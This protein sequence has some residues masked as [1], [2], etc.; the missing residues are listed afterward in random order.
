MKLYLVE[1]YGVIVGMFKTYDQ[2]LEFANSIT[3]SVTISTFAK[4]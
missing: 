2:A 1:N 4:E 3:G